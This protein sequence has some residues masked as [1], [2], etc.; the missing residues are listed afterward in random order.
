VTSDRQHQA[1]RANARA[2][3]GPKTAQGKARAARNAFRHGLR[4]P[5][6]RDPASAE[7]IEEVIG[8][9]GAD[10]ADSE[11]GAKLHTFAEALVDLRRVQEARHELIAASL[12]DPPYEYSKERARRA[13][14]EIKILGRMIK[15]GESP[16]FDRLIYPHTT[17]ASKYAEVLRD[18]AKRLAAIDRYERRAASRLK[19]AIRDL[20]AAG[21]GWRPANFDGAE[22]QPS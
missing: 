7:Q 1:N 18:F 3:T 15:G 20:D 12:D 6:V 2:S 9:V 22:P 21:F 11:T 5:V 8:A 14:K 10:K 4:V 16:E 13:W 19:F 17:E